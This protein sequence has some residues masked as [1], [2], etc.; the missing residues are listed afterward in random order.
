MTNRYA[1][2]VQAARLATLLDALQG[3]QIS[4]AERRTLEWLTGWETDTI[5]NLAGLFTKARATPGAVNR[6]AL[7]R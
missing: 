5:E 4:A 1:E 6:Q 3:V 2:Q 7:K